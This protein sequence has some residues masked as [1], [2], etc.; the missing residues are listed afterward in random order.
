MSYSRTRGIAPKS[1]SFFDP[2]GNEGDSMGYEIIPSYAPQGATD[3]GPSGADKMKGMFNAFALIGLAIGVMWFTRKKPKKRKNPASAR[4]KK[5]ARERARLQES[6]MK[7]KARKRSK[8]RRTP[9]PSSWL[10]ASR[11]GARAR[12]GGRRRPQFN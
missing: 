2:L 9:R 4:A 3:V 5:L 8:R 11:R 1:D 12:E 7:K 6:G 10:S